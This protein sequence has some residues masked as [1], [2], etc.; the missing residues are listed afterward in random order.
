[1]ICN[2]AVIDLSTNYVLDMIVADP[3]VDIP[4]PNTILVQIPENL[5]I[6]TSCTWTSSTGFVCAINTQSE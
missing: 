1:M 6:D 2:C 4:Y 3:D 5:T